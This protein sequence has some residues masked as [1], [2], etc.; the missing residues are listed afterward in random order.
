MPNG[1]TDTADEVLQES[2]VLEEK[3]GTE[4]NLE[5]KD[6]TKEEE[7]S[8][9][10]IKTVEPIVTKEEI[11]EEEEMNRWNASNLDA[12]PMRRPE[13]SVEQCEQLLLSFRELIEWII[14]K[15]TELSS[16]PSIGGDV[17]VILRQQEENRNLRRQIEEKRPLIENGLLAGRQYVAKEDV[18]H[19]ESSDSEGL[20]SESFIA[21]FCI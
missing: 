10:T 5:A 16:Q 14:K 3:E 9:E 17:A 12:I 15:E 6:I 7:N 13:I 2:E 18:G 1:Q 8:E 19:P 4:D 20:L 21:F 11:K